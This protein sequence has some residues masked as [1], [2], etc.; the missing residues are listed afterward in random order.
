M[1][2]YAPVP[3]TEVVRR[4][5]ARPVVSAGA[6]ARR[7]LTNG[8]RQIWISVR[9]PRLSGVG[10][11]RVL[12]AASRWWCCD[13]AA[14]LGQDPARGARAEVPAV[15]GEFRGQSGSVDF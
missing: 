14:G 4:A 11:P 3:S 9:S 10:E 1:L 6:A 15:L 8:Q 5:S 2:P 7:G 13:V 12:V